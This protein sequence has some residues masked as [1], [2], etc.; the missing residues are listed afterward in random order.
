[1]LSTRFG[2]FRPAAAARA[3]ALLR[4]AS[5]SVV[6]WPFAFGFFRFQGVLTMRET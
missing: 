3:R 4:L 2:Y 5:V 1:M 6:L